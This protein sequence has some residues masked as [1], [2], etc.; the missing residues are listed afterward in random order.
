MFSLIVGENKMLI[1]DYYDVEQDEEDE[2]HYKLVEA[3]PAFGGTPV[4]VTQINDR[5]IGIDGFT[6]DAEETIQAIVEPTED[7]ELLKEGVVATLTIPEGQTLFTRVIEGEKP[8][9]ETIYVVVLSNATADGDITGYVFDDGT[10]Y[11]YDYWYDSLGKGSTDE[12]LCGVAGFILLSLFLQM[13]LWT[14][15]TMKENSLLSCISTRIQNLPRQPLFITSQ[16][17]KQPLS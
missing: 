13:V 3:T 6:A 12:V 15:R 1:S 11:I 2:E 7:E 17:W 4:S 5:T 14:G 10:I 9:E 16:V 8:G